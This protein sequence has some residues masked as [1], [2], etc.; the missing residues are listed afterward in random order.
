MTF[1]TFKF[2]IIWCFRFLNTSYNVISSV[3]WSHHFSQP[4]NN[5]SISVVNAS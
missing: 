1:T 3:R 2:L 4:G 5:S